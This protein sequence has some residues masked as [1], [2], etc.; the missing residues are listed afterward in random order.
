MPRAALRL[1]RAGLHLLWG[2]ATILLV[3]P[4]IDTRLQLALKRRWSRQLV[5]LLGVRIELRGNG[6][7]R[8]MAI[9]NH[10]SF[11]D[12]FVINAVAPAAFVS[13]DDVRQW[14]LIGWLCRR[15]DTVFLAR[16][17]RNAAQQVRATLAR[18]LERGRVVAVFPEG[19]TTDGSHVLPFHSAL[20]QAAIDAGTP[21]T[22]V[23]LAYRD[24]AGGRAMAPAYVGDTSLMECLWSIAMASGLKAVIEVEPPLPSAGEER[25]RL[26]AHVHRHIAH[27]ITPIHPAPPGVRR[28]DGTPGDPQAVPP[29]GHRPTGNPNPAPADS[30][31]A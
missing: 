18:T 20:F 17:S 11:L 25:R 8:G 6:E 4:W 28:E 26:A 13:K 23:I 10:I 22:P 12:I 21:V 9:A 5:H 16:G 14:P 27:R 30:L 19:T 31:P 29:S 1:A 3:Y 2:A 7:I 15:T 24:G